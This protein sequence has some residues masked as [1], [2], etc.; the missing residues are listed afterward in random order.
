MAAGW[1]YL[2]DE[3]ESAISGTQPA[4]DENIEGKINETV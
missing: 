1:V 2:R 4:T 3:S